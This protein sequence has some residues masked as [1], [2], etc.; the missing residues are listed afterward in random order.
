MAKLKSPILSMGATGRLGK[1]FSLARR[2]GQNIIE[3]RPIPTDAKSTAQLFNRQIFIDAVAAWHALSKEEQ[4]AW[5]GVCP[6]LTAYQCFMSSQLKYEPPPIPIDIGSDPI[7]RASYVAIGYTII[8]KNNPANASGILHTVKVYAYLS[9]NGL[10]VG[11]FY[12]T[13]GN[14]LKCRDSELIGYVENKAVRTFTG[15]SIAVEE[16]DYIGCYYT[17]GNIERDTEGFLGIWGRYGE[18]IDPGD[19]ETYTFYAGDAMSLYG[20]G[21]AAA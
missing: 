3:R 6:G 11:T 1:L 15:L 4:Q 2:G 7:D 10:K 21:E 18:S 19:E 14:K 8:D 13:N 9:L 12:T 20:I 5:R 16:G 17:S